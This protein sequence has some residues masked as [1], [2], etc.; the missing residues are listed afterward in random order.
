MNVCARR[1]IISLIKLLIF[2][3]MIITQKSSLDIIFIL[4][5]SMTHTHIVQHNVISALHSNHGVNE[6][7]VSAINW[8]C[9]LLMI[10]CEGKL[11]CIA[12]PELACATCWSCLCHCD[13]L[14][15]SAGNGT[16]GTGISVVREARTVY[17]TIPKTKPL[18][19]AWHEPAKYP[20]PLAKRNNLHD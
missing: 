16:S 15:Q 8:G 11:F 7:I 4:C 20:F 9:R 10:W 6:T 18:L 17:C 19:R 13:K 3:V 2:I 14:K 1:A 12:L 5:G